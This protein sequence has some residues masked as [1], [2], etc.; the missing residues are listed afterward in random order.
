M[1]ASASKA[2]EIAR[3]EAAALFQ[4]RTIRIQE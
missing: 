4:E 2:D 1:S 3:N